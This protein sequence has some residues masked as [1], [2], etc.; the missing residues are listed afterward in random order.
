MIIPDR[1]KEFANLPPQA[2]PVSFMP[3]SFDLE[4][5]KDY[6]YDGERINIKVKN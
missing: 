1:Y 4:L 2:F 3:A 6:M 5:L